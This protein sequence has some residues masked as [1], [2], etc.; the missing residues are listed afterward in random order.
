MEQIIAKVQPLKTAT[1]K[2]MA[3]NLGADL[4][5]EAT[6]VLDAVTRVLMQRMPEDEFIKFCDTL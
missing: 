3:V 1:L 6:M 2:E 5:T 4:S